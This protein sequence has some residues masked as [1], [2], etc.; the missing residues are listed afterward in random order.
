MPPI[1]RISAPDDRASESPLDTGT[2]Q[3]TRTGDPTGDLT[4]NLVLFSSFTNPNITTDDYVLTGGNIS[5]NGTNATVVIPNGQSSVDVT[6]TPVDD[7]LP[8]LDER[9]GI[10]INPSPS[11]A[12]MVEGGSAFVTIAASDL[13]GTGNFIVTNT[14]DSGSGSLRQAILDANALPGADTIIFTSPIFNDSTPDTIALTGGSID[15]TGDT[16]IVGTGKDLLTIQSSANFDS[17]V[18]KSAFNISTG[19]TA[20]ISK[21]RLT[22]NGL[23]GIN[24]AGN[25]TLDN[26]A[27]GGFVISV[28]ASGQIVPLNQ[29]GAGIYNTGNLIVKNSTISG[30]STDTG[31]DK[32][33]RGGG[34]YNTGTLKVINSKI[35]DNFANAQGGGIYNAGTATITNATINANSLSD[36]SFGG[37]GSGGTQGGGIYN[38]AAGTLTITGSAIT[39]NRSQAR[40]TFSFGSGGGINNLG[41]AFLFNSTIAGNSVRGTG[42][43][44]GGIDNF[45]NVTISDSTITE[46]TAEA[47]LFE[48]TAI[49]GVRSLGTAIVQN[50]IIAGNSFNSSLSSVP[51]IRVLAPDVSGSFVDNGF[52][53]IGDGTSTTGS[54]T[55]SAGFT[56]STL[57]GTRTNPINPK[58]APLANN[59]GTTLTAG[60]RSD[61]PAI[62]AGSNSLIPADITDL[63]G[64]GDVTE[65]LPFDQRGIGFDRIASGTVDIGAFEGSVAANRAPT[66]NND[67]ATLAAGTSANINV[68]TNDSDPDGDPLALSITTIPGNGTAVVNNNGTPN[69]LTDDFIVYSP[70]AGFCGSDSFNYTVNDGNGGTSTAR[71]DIT[72]GG[73]NFSGTVGNDILSG[74]DC[75]DTINAN[76]GTDTVT[77][78]KGNDIL[79]GGGGNDRFIINLGDGNDT[80][81]DFTGVGKGTRPSRVAIAE[82]DTVQFVGAGLTAH[83]LLLTQ[84]GANLELSFDGVN[85]NKVTLNNVALENLDNLLKSTG[86]SVDLANIFFDGEIQPVDSFDV[87]DASFVGT[88]IH[89]RNTVTFLNDLSNTVSGYDNSNDVINGQGGDDRLNGRSGDDVLRGGQGNDALIGGAGN[90]LLVGNE[91][92]D[93]FVYDTGKTF[94]SAQIG[95]DTIADFVSGTD[96]IVL[97]KTTFKA[98]TSGVG[99]GFSTT[100]EFAIVS[101]DADAA[102]SSAL[103]VYNS[104][105]G[106][107]FYN[108]NKSS[109]GF[110][111]GA[112]FATV[113]SPLAATDFTIQA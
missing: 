83:N 74:T 14:N 67:M 73:G 113:S 38:A 63:D 11:S 32:P 51:N 104:A 15:I 25:L 111:S 54:T 6:L 77:G 72:V 88:S 78:K 8:E 33:T 76:L 39:N 43:N 99:A 86:A 75:D 5:I 59:G 93:Q 41:T 44:G 22:G 106:K 24:N 90:D 71:V 2:Y 18:L 30:N 48:P 36:S 20:D 79:T 9:V 96:K 109:S 91:G 107:L 61:S 13:D 62:N 60:L 112:Q 4:V 89:R 95:V 3:I 29:D 92:A 45:G 17:N 12:Y 21:L 110:G 19:V 68:L 56:T 66:A 58:L 52:N 23:R 40:S 87:V 28:F 102:T 16:K 31:A 42:G 100:G 10:A 64:D 69:N 37:S 27:L 7:N 105:N 65:P 81:T 101:T 103:V 84:T 80:I 55:S 70:A 35:S 53:L 1:V 85:G 94:A 50:S 57:V 34:I 26:A 82:A 47:I 49:G 46:N 97:S 108:Q 98:L